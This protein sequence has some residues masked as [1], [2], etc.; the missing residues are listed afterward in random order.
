MM[1]RSNLL[2]LERSKHKEIDWRGLKAMRNIL[3]HEYAYVD[4]DEMW[5]AWQKEIPDLKRKISRMI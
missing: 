5:K 2:L 3:I 1:S 4:A